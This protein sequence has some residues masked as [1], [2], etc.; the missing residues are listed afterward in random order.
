MDCLI[1]YSSMEESRYFNE[2]SGWNKFQPVLAEITDPEECLKRLKYELAYHSRRA[3]AMRIL[4]KYNKLKAKE[5]E[6]QLYD[7]FHRQGIKS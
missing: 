1:E 5:M 6:A 2:M 4:Q 7:Y 3:M